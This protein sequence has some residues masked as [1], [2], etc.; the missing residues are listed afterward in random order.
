VRADGWV[1]PLDVPA[2]PLSPV[3][4]LPHDELAAI[5]AAGV[6]EFAAHVGSMAVDQ[7]H[8][9]TLSLPDISCNLIS[10]SY[11]IP[12]SKDSQRPSAGRAKKCPAPVFQAMTADANGNI[13]VL[14]GN[15]SIGL[16]TP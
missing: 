6:V 8:T 4:V 5:G 2:D 3:A 1:E 14:N 15:D 10:P 13:W 9:R 16:L 12:Q 11:G 7:V